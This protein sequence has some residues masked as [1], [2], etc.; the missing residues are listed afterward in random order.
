M[1]E[2]SAGAVYDAAFQNLSKVRDGQLLALVPGEDKAPST[3][4]T[5]W[6]AQWDNHLTLRVFKQLKTHSRRRQ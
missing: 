5:V 3:L 4:P 1:R 2:T 6:Q